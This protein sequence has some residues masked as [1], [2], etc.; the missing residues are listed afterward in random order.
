MIELWRL[1]DLFLLVYSLSANQ[2][3][4]EHQQLIDFDLSGFSLVNWGTK[5][6]YT[7]IESL[8]SDS[9]TNF[10]VKIF[11]SKNYILQSVLL[12]N[13]FMH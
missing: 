10:A 8:S 13:N 5:Q 6:K 9:D 11:N 3:N 4:L 7:K 12:K 1:F 2:S